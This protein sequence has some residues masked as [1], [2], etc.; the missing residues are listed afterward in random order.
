MFVKV[1]EKA[2]P[3]F[4]DKEIIMAALN[5]KSM[6]FES[7]ALD[8]N[9][10]QKDPKS[11]PMNSVRLLL[12]L[13]FAANMR[14]LDEQEL[15]L[16]LENIELFKTFPFASGVAMAR[17]LLDSLMSATFF[18]ASALRLL[19]QLVTGEIQR[20]CFFYFYFKDFLLL[21]RRSKF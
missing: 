19:R 7:N 8:I 20:F 14:Y 3:A 9:S 17:G 15:Y 4:A 16:G 21:K 1:P 18:N 2:E 11:K 6:D 10:P 13:S 5:I 12:D